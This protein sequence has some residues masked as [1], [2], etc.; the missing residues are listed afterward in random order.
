MATTTKFTGTTDISAYQGSG[1]SL[2]DFTVSGLAVNNKLL[3]IIY[4]KSLQ[5]EIHYNLNLLT[6]QKLKIYSRK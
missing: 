6:L 1:S 2:S 5:L 3:F 4:R